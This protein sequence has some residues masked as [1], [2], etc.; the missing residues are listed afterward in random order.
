[1]GH[2]GLWRLGQL[3]LGDGGT[4]SARGALIDVAAESGGATARDREQDFDMGPTDPLA[5]ALDE[6]CSCAAEQVG[7]PQGWPTHLSLLW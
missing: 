7:H 5:V 1:M 4:M 6:C 3:L 2:F